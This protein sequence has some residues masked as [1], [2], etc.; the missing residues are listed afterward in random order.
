M[1]MIEFLRRC[2]SNIR[3]NVVFHFAYPFKKLS[4]ILQDIPYIEGD[5]N[6]SEE[7]NNA[8]V[9]KLRTHSFSKVLRNAMYPQNML[10]NIARYGC[11]SE[12]VLTPDMDMIASDNLYEELLQF[13]ATDYNL[14]CEACAYIMPVY[15]IKR[16]KSL[17]HNKTQLLDFI[18]K[19]DARVFHIKVF[20]FNQENSN[21]SLWENDSRPEEPLHVLYNISNWAEFW[22][23]VYVASS[24]VPL[25]DERFVGYGFTRNT[26]VRCE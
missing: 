12:Y 24:E 7:Y 2:D 22:E 11:R 8:L 6:N 4:P 20:N 10:R 5:C 21:L 25:Y 1:K 19:E 9:N 18:K 14:L 3:N 23:P 16:E 13:L 26:Q 15:E 17:P